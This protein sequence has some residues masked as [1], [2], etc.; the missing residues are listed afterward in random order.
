MGRKRRI[1]T[2]E[3]GAVHKP[4]KAKTSNVPKQKSNRKAKTRTQKPKAQEKAPE[5]SELHESDSSSP[6]D[7]H[8]LNTGTNG[9][10]NDEVNNDSGAVE[11]V[12][13]AHVYAGEGDSPVQVQEIGGEATSHGAQFDAQSDFISLPETQEDGSQSMP[14]PDGGYV[15]AKG[16]LQIDELTFNWAE[17]P[18]CQDK[19]RS[20]QK[21]PMPVALHREIC[22]YIQYIEPSE[23]EKKMRKEV[24]HRVETC[25]TEIWPLAKVKVLGSYATGLYLP[26]GDIDIVV[27]GEWKTVPLNTLAT[28]LREEKIAD[29]LQVISSAQVPIIKLW[30]TL[31]GLEMDISFNT[32]GGPEAAEEVLN[33]L[34]EYPVAHPLIMLVKHFLS[35]RMLNEVF[36]GGLGSFSLILMVISFLQM[37]PRGMGRDPEFMKTENLG[38]LLMEFFELYGIIFNYSEVAISILRN[39]K[40]FQKRQRRW[41]RPPGILTL[42][43]PMDTVNDPGSKSFKYDQVR[44]AF[45]HAY[46]VLHMSQ[47]GRRCIIPE[48]PTQ[49]SQLLRIPADVTEYREWVER[50]WASAEKKPPS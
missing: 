33:L 3:S 37:H 46:H 14:E 41:K 11:D 25:I 2:T 17:L 5:D 43:D 26:T 19:G 8:S 34:E 1:A 6:D 21:L 50:K 18:W 32:P 20:Y 39:G 36:S 31:S 16:A 48:C 24:L 10:D 12:V 40:Y 7:V 4:K 23:A 28:A 35:Q 15:V 45:A 13:D 44:Q 38:V 30:D 42:E 27:Y 22:D 29:R 49:L 9:W 47:I